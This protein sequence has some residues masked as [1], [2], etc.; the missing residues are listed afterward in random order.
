[1]IFLN[2]LAWYN[3]VKLRSPVQSILITK[4]EQKQKQYSLANCTLDHQTFE[5]VQHI[6]RVLRH[7]TVH[8]GKHVFY[9][10][11]WRDYIR[12]TIAELSHEPKV[13][14]TAILVTHYAANVREQREIGAIFLAEIHVFVDRI[15]GHSHYLHAQCFVLIDISLKALCFNRAA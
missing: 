14:Q 6:L 10:P 1:M 7:S 8:I 2:F 13:Q 15:N 12:L 4:T 9:F 3:I 11:L 5:F